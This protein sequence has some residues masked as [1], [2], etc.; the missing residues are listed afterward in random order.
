MAPKAGK[1][2]KAREDCKQQKQ[3]K[4]AAI[5]TT[6]T[7]T[8]AISCVYDIIGNGASPNHKL[9]WYRTYPGS[10]CVGSA[11]CVASVLALDLRTVQHLCSLHTPIHCI[12]LLWSLVLQGG[13][14]VQARHTYAIFDDADGTNSVDPTISRGRL[15]PSDVLLAHFG[16]SKQTI[17]LLSRHM[18]LS[19]L[20]RG[21]SK[22]WFFIC[23]V[24]ARA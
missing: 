5:F 24:L 8:S 11:H 18:L 17:I 15:E 9:D 12:C 4:K 16:E 13:S 7:S 2:G 1:A 3:Q 19:E 10:S 22:E 14:A 21:L 6:R 20:F 23:C